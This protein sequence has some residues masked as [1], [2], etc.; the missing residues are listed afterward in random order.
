MSNTKCCDFRFR[1]GIPPFGSNPQEITETP[2]YQ[3][4]FPNFDEK[5][6]ALYARGVST[7][8]IQAHIRELYGLEISPALVSALTAAVMEEVGAWQARPLEPSYALV[9]FDALRVKIRDEGLVAN[10]AVYLAIGVRT[11]GHKEVLGIWI[12]HSEGAKFW[13]RVMN[14]LKVRGTHDILIAVV[15]GLKGFA[16]AITAVFPETVVQTCI[17]HLIRYSMRFASW[18]ER[19]HLAGALKP[20]YRAANAAAAESELEAFAAGPWGEKYPAIAQGW[21]SKWEEIIPF[22]AFS[23]EV[24]KIIYTTNA[25]ESLN[26]QVRKAIRNKGHF[27][28]EQAAMKLIWLALRQVAEKW[29]NPSPHWHAARAEL[30]IQFGERFV[31]SD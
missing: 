24:R 16:Q 17:V 13:L 6:V 22:F 12:E 23:P 28:S 19:K 29:K 8:E 18:K 27:T 2:K 5:I 30:A 1:S 21:R 26:S 15:D 20:I 7:R 3:R 10:R 4:R 25:I 11:S 31:V 9:F 14:D